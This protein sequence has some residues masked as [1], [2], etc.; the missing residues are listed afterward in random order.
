MKE[1]TKASLDRYV[2]DKIPT[3]DFLQAVLENNLFNAFGRADDENRKDL[4]EII[5]Y[6]Y[7]ELPGDCWGSP[8]KVKNWLKR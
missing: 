2:K 4:R 3:G 7:H 8:E 1:S 5:R 6:I